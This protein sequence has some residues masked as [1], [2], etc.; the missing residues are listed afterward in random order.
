[1]PNGTAQYVQN[2]WAGEFELNK[3]ASIND[4]MPSNATAGLYYYR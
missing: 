4:T 3:Q 1:M 2:V